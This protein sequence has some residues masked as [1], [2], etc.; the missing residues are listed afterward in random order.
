MIISLYHYELI[1]FVCYYSLFLKIY[2]D[3]NIP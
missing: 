3:I 2:F 1:Q